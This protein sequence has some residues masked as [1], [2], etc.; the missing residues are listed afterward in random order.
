VLNGHSKPDQFRIVVI[1]KGKG[2][3]FKLFCEG[4]VQYRKKFTTMLFLST[5]FH[6]REVPHH[7][8]EYDQQDNP[9][10]QVIFPFW[11]VEHKIKV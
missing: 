2:T 3:G 7:S 11:S 10:G 4:S 1:G 5:I 9:Q 8:Q 6:G